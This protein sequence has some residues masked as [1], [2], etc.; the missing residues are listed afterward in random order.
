MVGFETYWVS[1]L[2]DSSFVP[3]HLANQNF[4]D[5]I[6]FN[7]WRF[8]SFN[9]TGGYAYTLVICKKF[10]VMAALNGSLGIGEYQLTQIGGAKMD[11]IYPNFS[12]NQKFGVGYHFNR[13]YIGMSLAN[14]QYFSPTPIKQTTIRWQTGNLRFNI[15]YRIS[16]KGDV[17]I[18]PWKWF[19]NKS[20]VNQN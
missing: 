6:N 19:G 18:R 5:D 1:S 2:A 4:F 15:A 12:L 3:S 8:Y 7:K 14:F 13:L 10:F 11:R 9:L 20:S 16:L 17:E